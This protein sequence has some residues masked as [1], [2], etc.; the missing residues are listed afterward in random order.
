MPP[1]HS[2]PARAAR[3]PRLA[4]TLLLACAAM[5]ALAA[6]DPPL[7]QPYGN[8]Y[9]EW[10]IQHFGTPSAR[11]TNVG[12]M[13]T[14]RNDRVTL[15]SD[16]RPKAETAD[17]NWSNSYV[18]VRGA[19]RRGAATFGYDLQLVIDPEQMLD[20]KIDTRDA[21]VFVETPTFGRVAVGKMD[22]I[23]KEFGDRVRM[24]GVSSGNVVS[25]ARVLSGVGW[26]GQGETTFN[27][28]RSRMIT[29]Y[30]PV[31]SGF[32][33]G[34]SY[35]V[36]DYGGDG[37]HSTLASASLRW[38]SGPWYGALALEEHRNW[39]PLSRGATPAATSILNN[40]ATTDSRDRGVRL[41]LG[42]TAGAWRVGAD[43]SRLMYSETD[44]IELA[45][46]FRQYR[47]LTWQVSA[48]YKWSDRL[49]FGVNHARASAG[50]CAL[51]GGVACSTTGLG[52]N[53]TSLG[54]LYSLNRNVGVFAL[55]VKMRNNPAAY[56]GSAA[57]GGTVDS[58]AVGVK[59]SFN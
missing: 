55:A 51:S 8:L 24:L 38:L 31:W 45:G 17:H 27:N 13:G 9:P 5:P 15:S 36:G 7:A 4:A 58:A 49:R 3:G 50:D 48:D 30:S 11:G 28:R 12:N 47:N 14:L 10:L 22:S 25:T 35:A 26:R 33:A 2:S 29:W 57:Q 34:A 39:L 43:L 59:I 21:F 44:S 37:R 41:S 20:E 6:D 40:A 18:G 56:Y 53:Q 42:W 1:P 19:T 52:G 16:A 23:Y 46:K 54:V 32:E